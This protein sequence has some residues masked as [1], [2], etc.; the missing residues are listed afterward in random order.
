[1]SE[2][3]FTKGRWWTSIFDDGQHYVCK[4]NRAICQVTS[5]DSSGEQTPNAYLITAA[6]EMYEEIEKDIE[7]LKHEKKKY[8]LGSDELRVINNRIERKEKLLAKARGE[9][10]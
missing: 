2:A 1:M 7:I 6:P 3:K 4:D 10:C 8:V 5:F 9:Q